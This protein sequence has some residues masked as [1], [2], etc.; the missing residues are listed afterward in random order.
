MPCFML[1]HYQ[2]VDHNPAPEELAD[3][4]ARWQ[5]FTSELAASG[6][7]LCGDALQPGHTATTVSFGAAESTAQSGTVATNAMVV[8]GYYV[9]DGE[10]DSAV[11]WA[12]RM[13]VEP[14]SSIEIRPIKVVGSP[15]PEVIDR[16]TSAQRDLTAQFRV[17]LAV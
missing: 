17:A 8:R 4:E 13:P 1:L 10:A 5:S 15:D 2:P 11:E 3:E 7:M 9:F 14:G 12:S 6:H 16:L